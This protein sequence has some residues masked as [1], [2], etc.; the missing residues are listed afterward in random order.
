MSPPSALVGM[1]EVTETGPGQFEGASGA[2]SPGRGFGGHAMALALR[3]GQKTVTPD[4][5][6]HVLH[7][8]FLRPVE[9]GEPIAFEVVR[10]GD[11]RSFSRRTVKGLQGGKERIAVSLTFIEPGEAGPDHSLTMP[12]VP[13]PEELAGRFLGP[14]EIR[15]VEGDAVVIGALPDPS[16]QRIWHRAEAFA[17]ED[18]GL[19]DCALVYISDLTQLWLTLSVN[20]LSFAHKSLMLA[21]IDHSMWFHRPTRADQWLLYDQ[22]C[23]STSAGTGLVQGQIYDAAGRAVATV[24]QSG[25]LR[26][27]VRLSPQG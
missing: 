26:N 1:L 22:L 16:R 17:P 8:Q 24:V 18:R 13:G 27:P 20:G 4:R 7:A 10:E 11:S 14:V 2:G 21:S 5:V 23:P 6:V 25:I 15:E 12:H 3:A 19:H 9:P